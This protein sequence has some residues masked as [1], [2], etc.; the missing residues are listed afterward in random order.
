MLKDGSG[1]VRRWAADALGWVGSRAGSA[2]PALIAGLE[3]HDI[4]DRVTILVALGR[5]VPWHEAVVRA[6]SRRS[7]I[8]RTRS[9]SPRSMPWESTSTRDGTWCCQPC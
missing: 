9:A 1:D 6:S 5:L 8:L 2:V 4:A 7:R 3:G